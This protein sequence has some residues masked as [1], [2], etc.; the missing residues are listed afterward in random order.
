MLIKLLKKLMKIKKKYE[1]IIE[2]ILKNKNEKS[3]RKKSIKQL[4]NKIADYL[5]LRRAERDLDNINKEL[6]KKKLIII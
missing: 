3:D 6:N 2:I 1:D 5:L 4:I